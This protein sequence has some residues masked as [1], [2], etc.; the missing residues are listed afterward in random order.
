MSQRPPAGGIGESCF[1]PR[2]PR[3]PA[4]AKTSPNS[5]KANNPC[6]D[7]HSVQVF[8][9]WLALN[10]EHSL[11]INQWQ[12]LESHLV[13]QKNW[14]NISSS[15]R[16][17]LPEAAQL[18]TI[19]NRLGAVAMKRQELL[20]LLPLAACSSAPGLKL[21]LATALACVPEDEN[22]DAHNIIKSAIIDLVTL[23]DANQ[24]A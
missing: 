20:R 14:F 3:R 12:A 23:V 17:A 6:A 24:F 21:K 22:E 15:Q 16:K 10:A 2:P 11:L 1:E 4:K 13:K 7:D 19:E 9:T 18:Q 5:G 8:E